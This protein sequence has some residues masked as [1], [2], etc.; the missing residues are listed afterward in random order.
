MRN[1]KKT[2]SSEAVLNSSLKFRAVDNKGPLVECTH[3]YALFLGIELVWLFFALDADSVQAICFDAVFLVAAMVA[4]KWLGSLLFN[5]SGSTKS[6][7][8]LYKEKFQAQCWQ[9]ARNS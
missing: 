8:P 2:N 9:I 3:Y 5:R 4:V 7:S 6:G 1:R